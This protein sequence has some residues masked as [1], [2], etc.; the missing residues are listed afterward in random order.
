MFK[1]ELL[2]LQKYF[3]KKFN[4]KFIR[5]NFFKYSFFVL[6]VKKFEKNLRFGVNYRKL[7]VIIEK[8]R[9]FMFFV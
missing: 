4:K 3:K 7:N 8:N 9:Y 5:F 6:F 1:N 2:I